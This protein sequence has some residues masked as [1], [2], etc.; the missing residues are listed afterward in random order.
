MSGQG[1]VEVVA[2]PNPFSSQATIEFSKKGE[3]SYITVEIYSVS[4]AKVAI[5]FDG[6]VQADVG[7]TKA[8]SMPNLA[9]GMYMYRIVYSNDNIVN[10]K[11]LLQK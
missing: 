6:L 10:G 2:F 5:L 7:A 4:G 8:P 1:N 9:S 3:S 11:N